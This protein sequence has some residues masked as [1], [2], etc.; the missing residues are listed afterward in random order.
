MFA[1]VVGTLRSTID[2]IVLASKVDL[3]AVGI[4]GFAAYMVA[5]LQAPMRSMVAITIPIL[6]RAWKDKNH[7]EISR[8]YKRSSIN[9]LSFSLLVFFCIWLNYEQAIT[10]FNINPQ[11]LH[12]KWVFF[13]LGVTAI[14][15]TGT[16]VNAQIIG[17]STYWRFE[18]WTSL[19]LTVLII[20]LSYFLTVKYGLVGPAIANLLS[21]TIYNT[22]RY[23]F[24]WKKFSLQP[25]SR[26]T[27]EV[28]SGA[29]II[30]FTINFIFASLNGL[31]ALIIRTLLFSILFILLIYWRNISPDMKPVVKN[32]LSRLN[33]SNK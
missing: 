4:F 19:L 5:M 1:I 29:V 12:A 25:F 20:P 28:I 15:E 11:Y 33:Q 30:Y 10:F 17:T 16:G 6:S 3:A 9:L 13:L 7:K 18:L 21:F 32:I 14:I 22:V 8:I 26:K 27:L 31:A 23:W 24:L 2:A